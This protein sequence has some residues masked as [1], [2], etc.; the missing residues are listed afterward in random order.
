MS[1]HTP[2]PWKYL[3][4]DHVGGA[5][6][7]PM[8]GPCICTFWN[9]NPD[10]RSEA[11]HDANARRIVACVNACEGI[12]PEAVPDLLAACEAALW[13]LGTDSDRRTIGELRLH[14][15]YEVPSALRSA[16]ARARGE[17]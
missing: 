4:P 5:A 14:S 13:L 3:P 12:N 8:E 9:E 6:I 11:E 10:L 2:E 17:S 15:L 7:I 16:I 1:E